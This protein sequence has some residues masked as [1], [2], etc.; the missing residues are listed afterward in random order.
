MK[1]HSH[2]GEAEVYTVTITEVNLCTFVAGMRCIWQW[3]SHHSRIV[4]GSVLKLIKPSV[5]PYEFHG[6]PLKLCY[7]PRVIL[8]SPYIHP[9]YKHTYTHQ[10]Q[11]VG[12]CMTKAVGLHQFTIHTCI[13]AHKSPI[14]TLRIR[15]V[16][17]MTVTFFKHLLL[18]N[19]QCLQLEILCLICASITFLVRPDLAV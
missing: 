9:T 6:K 8:R 4:S 15:L 10:W 11:M 14:H 5:H 19:S 12:T 3:S 18:H 2:Q 7:S 1:L 17:T 16:P 13:Q